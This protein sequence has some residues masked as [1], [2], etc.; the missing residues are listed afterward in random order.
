MSAIENTSTIIKKDEP[1]EPEYKKLNNRVK[2][3]FTI[4]YILLI[5]VATVT[6]IESLRTKVLYERHILN[7]ITCVTLVS[8]YFYSIFLEKIA[9]SEEKQIN[10]DWI[11]ISQNRYLDWSISTPLLLLILCI[12]LTSKTNNSVNLASFGII[13]LL[14]YFMFYMYY[15]GE[16]GDINK[17]I[18]FAFGILAFF[19]L[20]YTI[21]NL[22]VKNNQ[23]TGNITLYVSFLIIWLFYGVSYL[24]DEEYKNLLNNILD[25]ISKFF[26]G[27]GLWMY[28]SKMITI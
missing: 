13:T 2:Y 7:L 17:N 26:I 3:S 23:S 9:N 28:Y 12:F 19:S 6:A 14:N 21:Y 20:F 8:A 24:L 15:S 10:V 25:L 1:N 5:S 22:Y 16:T 4:T 27:F 18:G 11:K